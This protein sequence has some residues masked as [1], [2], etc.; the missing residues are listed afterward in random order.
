MSHRRRRKR[1][2]SA[3]MA[4]MICDTTPDF[5]SD[6]PITQTPKKAKVDNVFK[7][8]EM[9]QDRS[10]AASRLHQDMPQPSTDY[11]HPDKSAIGW[12]SGSE[13]C[14]SASQTASGK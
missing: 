13:T 9:L 3:L 4:K 10:R 12:G 2:A 8:Q 1:A 5:D 7:E 6:T 14:S 11:D